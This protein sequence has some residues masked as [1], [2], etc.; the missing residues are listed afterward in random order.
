MSAGFRV[1][2]IRLT[3]EPTCHIHDC[4]CACHPQ[5][6]EDIQEKRKLELQE[7]RRIRRRA[8]GQGDDEEGQEDDGDAG[9]V[10]RRQ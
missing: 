7:K 6:D 2:L 1:E 9:Q 4:R 10:S 3:L 5:L 8:K